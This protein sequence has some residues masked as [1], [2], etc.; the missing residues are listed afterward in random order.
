MTTE[1]DREQ[2]YRNAIEKAVQGDTR[3]AIELLLRVQ[4]KTSELVPMKFK[5]VQ[6]MYWKA[7]TPADIIV[8]AA[9]VGI[10]TEI[11]AEFFM[12]AMVIPG[13]EVLILAQRDD[14]ATKLFEI[15]KLFVDALP[16]GMRPKLGKDN[17]HIIE[18]DHGLVKKGM[19]SFITVGSAEAGTFG[20]GRPT[21]RL[22][23]T[24]VAFY[25]PRAVKVIGGI[26]ARMPVGISRRVEESTANGQEGYF[27]NEWNLATAGVSGK[28]AHFFAWFL[29]PDYV[30]D[31]RPGVRWHEAIGETTD[32]EEFLK[33]EHGLTDDQL[34]WRRWKVIDV[35]PDMFKQEFPENPDEAFLPIGSAVFPMEIV[36]KHQDDVMTPEYEIDDFT[37]WVGPI[38]GRPYVVCIDQASGDQRD[39]NQKPLDFSVITV[40]DA[41]TLDGP[42]ARVRSR[43]IT[44]KPLA[45]RA[46]DLSKEY[47]GALVVP[48]ANLAKYGFMDWLYEFGVENIYV[49][50]DSKGHPNP[51]YPMSVATKPALKDNFLDIMK[52][53]GGC[54][55]RSANLM[56]EIRNYR[57]LKGSGQRAMGA[58]VGGNDDELVTALFAFDPEVRA[59]AHTY[60][61]ARGRIE[62]SGSFTEQVSLG[63]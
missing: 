37:R 25:E 35:G 26:V 50:V 51:G 45:K 63:I 18:F 16:E 27:F 46:A 11:Q 29:D 54:R 3:D 12:D 28:V 31:Y 57:Y 52:V 22:L 13:L 17:E 60:A 20:R 6:D 15:S 33:R 61:R 24:E 62:G 38:L 41:V 14:T 43:E 42:L 30:L 59:Q 7:R 40:W 58:A 55:I 34:R 4:S 8:K 53:D 56:R 47:N 44:A 32:H 2:Q 10:T 49:H 9:Q 48:E 19:R 5:P 1:P 36:D 21:H 39:D 23:A